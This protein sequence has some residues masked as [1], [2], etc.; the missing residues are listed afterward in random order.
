M[1]KE[2]DAATQDVDI[3]VKITGTTDIVLITTIDLITMVLLLLAIF[4]QNNNM[5]HNGQIVPYVPSGAI[6]MQGGHVHGAWNPNKYGQ[7][8]FQQTSPNAYFHNNGSADQLSR[9][10]SM[11]SQAP[12]QAVVSNL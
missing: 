11:L 12:V 3:K 2:Q 10:A 9:S 8:P 5:S 6:M 4:Y 7:Q 1:V